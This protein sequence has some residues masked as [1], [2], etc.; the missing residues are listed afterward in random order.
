[1]YKFPPGSW[2]LNIPIT[3]LPEGHLHKER[4]NC[5]EQHTVKTKSTV[6]S[7]GKGRDV[8]DGGISGRALQGGLE[9]FVE[10]IGP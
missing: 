7:P 2:L 4:P 3:L 6:Q 5:P 1:M 9:G 8:R 10:G